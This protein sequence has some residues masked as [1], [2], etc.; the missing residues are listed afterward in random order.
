HRLELFVAEELAALERLLDS[1]FQ[2]LERMLVELAEAHVLR[3]EAALQKVVGKRAQQV[4]GID[5][6]ILSGI[7]RVFDPLHTSVELWSAIAG[8]LAFIF[9]DCVALLLFTGEAALLGAADTAM[10]V[11]SFQDEL[12]GRHS[13]RIRLTRAKAQRPHFFEQP[14]NGAELAQHL[15]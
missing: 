11:K 2:V 6:E 5:A 3:V 9:L 14:L 8:A 4:F 7:A 1:A 12:G 10:G 15:G 13:D